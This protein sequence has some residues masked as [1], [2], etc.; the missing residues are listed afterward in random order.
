MSTTQNKPKRASY[1][2]DMSKNGWKKLKKVLPDSKSAT[3]KGG[4]PPVELKEV[5][6]AIF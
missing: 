6:N 2:S 5:I 3:E 1:P 4:R